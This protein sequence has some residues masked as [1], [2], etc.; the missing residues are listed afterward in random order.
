MQV[1]CKFVHSLLDPKDNRCFLCSGI[2]HGKKDCPQ[3]NGKRKVAKTQTEKGSRKGDKGKGKG[4]SETSDQNP[5]DETTG[6]DKRK[7]GESRMGEASSSGDSVSKNLGSQPKNGPN[8]ELNE[9]LHEASAL[10]KS[11]RPVLKAVHFREVLS[12]AST[13]T[14]QTGL[15]DGGATNALRRGSREEISRAELVTVELASGT[16]QLYQD[17]ITGTLLTT[18]EVEPIVPLRGVVDLGYKIKWDRNGCVVMHPV[19]GK[20]V[21]WLRNGCPVVR[22]EHA[23]QLIRDMEDMERTRKSQPKLAGHT[24]SDEVKVWWKQNF[25]EVPPSVV[26][27]MTGQHKGKPLLLSVLM[28]PY[29]SIAIKGT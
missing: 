13:E 5:K 20:L 18:S 22:E 28:K 12:K 11:L 9:L 10:M 15:L 26:S 4:G 6:R 19:H 16:T 27:Y 29:F 17:M 7:G 2:G 21:C 1:K 3:A 25:P 8:P 14:V 23:L 24:V